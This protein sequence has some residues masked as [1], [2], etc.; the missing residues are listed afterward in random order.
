[1]LRPL[2]I[3]VFFLTAAACEDEAPC[4]DGFGRH[5][6]ELRGGWDA[7]G[8]SMFGLTRGTPAISG[9][10]LR[11][12]ELHGTAIEIFDAAAKGLIARTGAGEILTGAELDGATF[13]AFDGLTSRTM[14]LH[15]MPAGSIDPG[16]VRYGVTVDGA[17]ACTEGQVGVFVRGAWD[18]DGN[19]TGDD[20]ISFACESGAV[21]K[22]V[23]WGYAPWSAGA[24]L[25]QTCTRVV[26]AD[27]CGDGR[28]YTEDGAL[29]WVSE[30]S[31]FAEVEA[32]GYTREAGWGPN[33]AVCLDHQRF[34]AISRTGDAVLPACAA[35]LPACDGENDRALLYNGSHM[36]PLMVCR[37]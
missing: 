5:E 17:P 13:L 18:E 6:S 10:E 4:S 28:S 34:E 25:H 24:E 20:G 9:V 12:G 19:Q 27:Y 3:A 30:A 15:A 14:E 8:R 23:S 32:R 31:A 36:A 2:S 22:C 29:I 33:G 26:R 16:F 21:F 7:N 1:M 37:E 11:S 35:K